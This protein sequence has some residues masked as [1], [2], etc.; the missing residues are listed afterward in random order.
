MLHGKQNKGDEWTLLSDLD[1]DKD[2]TDAWIPGAVRQKSSILK[3]NKKA[4][5]NM[6][7]F[8]LEI[9][10]SFGSD[11]VQLNEMFFNY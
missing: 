1:I 4:P 10:R 9:S 2:K 6:Q 8:R 11:A 7:Y 5:K 3:F